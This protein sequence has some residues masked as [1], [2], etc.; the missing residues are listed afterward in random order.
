MNSSFFYGRMDIWEVMGMILVVEDDL[1]IQETLKE[2]LEMKGYQIVLASS[3]R[4]AKMRFDETIDLV[5]M[6]IQLPDGDGVSL[7]QYIRQKS[8][9]PL[10]FLTVK[11]D[12]QTLI[13]ALNAGGDDYITK[14]FRANE[15]L[16]RMKSVTRRLQKN[17]DLV[18][19]GDLTIDLKKYVV[20][21][22]GKEI[23]LSAIGYEILFLLVRNQG[24]VITRERMIEFIEEKTK[25]IIEDNT[26]SVHVKRLREKIGKYKNQEYIETVRGIGYRWN[27][28]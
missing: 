17:K 19:T 6:D 23:I 8:E 28:M 11:N 12:E 25:N 3:C 5:I 9:V 18:E 16:A 1:G 22:Q 20:Y 4:E 13:E 26:V 2:L 15:L 21:K 14:P 27:N 24:M 7:C 10:L